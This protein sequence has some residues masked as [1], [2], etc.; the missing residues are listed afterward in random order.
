M[1]WLENFED[2]TGYKK[3]TDYVAI[4]QKKVSA[5]KRARTY[6]Q[7]NHIL[8]RVGVMLPS[9]IWSKK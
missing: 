5:Q 6:E 9:V 1:D 4:T 7:V 2:V 8:K 3:N